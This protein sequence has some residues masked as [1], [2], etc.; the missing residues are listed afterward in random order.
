MFFRKLPLSKKSR[1]NDFVLEL[2]GRAENTTLSIP[3]NLK[4]YVS[5]DDISL[6][7]QTLSRVEVL[8]LSDCVNLT[9]S[10]L[11]TL[12]GH[13]HLKYIS[14]S[15]LNKLQGKYLSHLSQRYQLKELN[16]LGNT[17]IRDKDL[18]LLEG[19]PNLSTIA[20]S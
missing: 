17:A 12:Q 3:E 20:F 19:N 5:D 2:R 8:D 4:D 7:I 9:G 15:Y 1:F 13:N 10:F 14:L 11:E 16:F 18:S 6:C